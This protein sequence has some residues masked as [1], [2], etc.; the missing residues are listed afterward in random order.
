MSHSTSHTNW[1]D[2]GSAQ[3]LAGQT[4]R[5]ITVG[6]KP[7][8]LSCVGGTFGAISNACNH[9]GGPLG[10]G[11]LD[12]EYI[13]CPWHYWKFHRQ[14][15]EGEP[16]YEKDCVPRH[17]VKLENGRVFVS[18]EP[19]TKRNKLPHAPHPLARE[20]EH[21]AGPP[22]VLGISTTAMDAGHPRP[23]TSEVLLESALAHARTSL[24]LETRLLKLSAL[25]F[26]ACEGFYSKS[27]QACTWPCSITQ[28]DP[29]DQMAEV[30]EGIVHWADVILVATPIR[31]GTA[32]SLYHKMVERMNCV[33][34]QITIRDNVLI[35]EGRGLHHHRG[36][37]QRSGRGR[38]DARLLRRDRLRLSALPLRGPQ[39]R[40]VGRGH[41]EQ[42]QVG[43]GERGVARG[44]AG[45]AR[46][47]RR[48]RPAP[49][50]KPPV[51][52]LDPARRPQGAPRGPTFVAARS[53]ASHGSAASA[54]PRVVGQREAQRGSAQQRCGRACPGTGVSLAAQE[55]AA[56][57]AAWR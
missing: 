55:A 36:P 30:Y 9:V 33:Q 29:K 18:A 54:G 38:R 50:A 13:V 31:W 17:E 19:V 45:A 52:G 46:A 4:L 10:E 47:R 35:R 48:A 2:V 20:P 27:A 56:A 53:D 57:A 21:H 14:S 25:A 49:A 23:S 3:E 39:P 44:H 43:A 22:R 24:G 5:S 32:S 7:V 8:A 6:R 26:R 41:G 37:G 28:M 40:L 15:G 34:N 16:G 51:H 11:Q 1:I 12:G 42:R